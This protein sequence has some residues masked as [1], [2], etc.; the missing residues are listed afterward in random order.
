MDDAAERFADDVPRIHDVRSISEGAV[1]HYYH[2]SLD[3]DQQTVRIFTLSPTVSDER[4]R[5]AFIHAAGQWHNPSTHANIV[6][7]HDR[8]RRPRPWIAA[9]MVGGKR[10]D[11]VQ[12]ELSDP[13]IG[14]VIADAAEAIRNASLYNTS[15]FDLTP[16]S[17]WVC[18]TDDGL[19]GLVDGWGL[20]R[21]C[22]VAAGDTPVT[23]YTP[24]ELLD[25]PDSG[26]ERTD[27]YGLG[28]VAYAALTGTAPISGRDLDTA[29]R[30]NDITPPT[31]V[32]PALPDAVDDVLLT[33]LAAD[34]G[35]R[36][37]S[38]YE[39]KTA[40]EQA[41]PADSDS[42]GGASAAGGTATQSPAATDSEPDE[43]NP[44][45]S[46]AH[47]QDTQTDPQ[48]TGP[49]D[50]SDTTAGS[51]SRRAVLGLVGLGGA[52]AG[53]GWLF[54]QPLSEL[55][56]DFLSAS[57]SSPRPDS[58]DGRDPPSGEYLSDANAYDGFVD[59]RGNSTVPVRVGGGDGLAFDP[60]AVHID[61]E[62]TIRW[63][64]TGRGGSHNVVAIDGT[65]KSGAPTANRDQAFTYT[66]SEPGST[67]YYCL[68]HRV[69]GMKGLV[70]VGGEELTEYTDSYTSGDRD[71]TPSSTLDDYLADANAYDGTVVNALGADTVLVGVGAGNS[72]LAFDPAAVRISP[73]T[74][75]VWEW[76][77]EGGAHNVIHDVDASSQSVEAFDSGSTQSSGTFEYTF[78]T[79]GTYLYYCTPHKAVGM[80]GAVIVE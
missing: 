20:T 14:S 11:V 49:A 70:L 59:A 21:A 68:P 45:P 78:S 67:S 39:F 35:E 10:L 32:S 27:V 31:A 44:Q 3:P 47:S 76:T 63:E 77:G 1:V 48:P 15:H 23:A 75:V 51:P 61:P 79:S 42:P 38:A 60:P 2:G 26:S 29:I 22:Q 52:G 5:E 33:A 30:D 73:G 71:S 19:S 8:D 13:E 46:N 9:D 16:E 56:R 54:W 37:S 55:G 12:S 58:S 65:F 17:I 53:L 69:S 62:T 64:W 40:I 34:P 80:K 28:A 4:V 43:P 50:K 74:T 72:G 66:F 6:T 57:E 36:Q 25:S 7:I 41:L 18:D 24:P